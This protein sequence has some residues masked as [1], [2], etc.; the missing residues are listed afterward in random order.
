M[1]EVLKIVHKAQE[2][3]SR[4]SQNGF[5]LSRKGDIVSIEY[6]AH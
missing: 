6:G 1:L 3:S 4:M 2:F 5:Y